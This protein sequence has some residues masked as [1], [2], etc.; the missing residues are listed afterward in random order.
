MKPLSHHVRKLA[1][2]FE[3]A[4]QLLDSKKARKLIEKA[5]KR[6]AKVMEALRKEKQPQPA[7]PVSEEG[8]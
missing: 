6:R 8:Q 7:D 2:Y 1:D 3:R 5:E 4:E